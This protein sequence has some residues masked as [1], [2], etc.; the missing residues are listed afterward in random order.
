MKKRPFLGKGQIDI[1]KK[2]TVKTPSKHYELG[3]CLGKNLQ[4]EKSGQPTLFT[5]TQDK[6]MLTAP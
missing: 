3:F 1:V 2:T 5:V 6:V 4:S